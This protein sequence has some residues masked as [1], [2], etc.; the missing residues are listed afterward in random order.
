MSLSPLDFE[1]LVNDLDGQITEA[2]KAIEAKQKCDELEKEYKHIH[3]QLEALDARLQQM[4]SLGIA[5]PPNVTATVEVMRKEDSR[6]AAELEELSDNPPSAF[7]TKELHAPAP[8]QEIDPTLRA[9]MDELIDEMRASTQA[10]HTME[11]D[12]KSFLF[13]IWANRWRILAEAVGQHRIQ[14]ERKMMAA[15]AVLKTVIQEHPE[16]SHY[17]RALHRNEPGDWEALLAT[18]QQG[19]E[20]VYARRRMRENTEAQLKELAV[21]L[22]EAEHDEKRVRHL[23]REIAKQKSFWDDLAAVCEPKKAD[24][25]AEFPFLWSEETETTS[26]PVEGK[27]L[28]NRE[29]TSRILSRMMSKALIGECHGP[30]DKIY[31]G[32][33]GHDYGRAKEAL[34]LMI[35]SG[36]IRHKTLQGGRVSVENKWVTPAKRF[37]AGQPL[38]VKVIDDWCQENP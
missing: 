6:L 11:T 26:P 38:G 22:S 5:P 7:F 36:I 16:A 12:E 28:A 4:V 35:K 14:G 18:A 34:E 31:K 32:F 8:Q 10:L 33:P 1:K 30:I 21:L 13:D 37:I 9:Q 29:I 17:I 15:Y 19:L 25:M 23:I 3:H 2:K 27:K 24:L 20:G